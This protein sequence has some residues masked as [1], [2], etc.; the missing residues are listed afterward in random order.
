MVNSKSAI[1][2]H[3]SFNIL[4]QA[5][6]PVNNKTEDQTAESAA[7]VEPLIEDEVSKDLY[8]PLRGTV[9]EFKGW[10]ILQ[11][12]LC[13]YAYFL[14]DYI[15]GKYFFSSKIP[16]KMRLFRFSGNPNGNPM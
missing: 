4:S 5:G 16:L 8:L 11:F 15:L 10:Q 7:A 1:M 14:R 12:Q 13:R 3:Q 9:S 6:K 2:E